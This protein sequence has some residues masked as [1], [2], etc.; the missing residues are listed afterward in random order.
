M[1][2]R[3]MILCCTSAALLCLGEALPR[4]GRFTRADPGNHSEPVVEEREIG[5]IWQGCPAGR[6]GF[7]CQVGT[8]T[9]HNWVEALLY[10]EG[11]TWGGQTDWRL[12]NVRELSSIVDDQR[13]SPAIDPQVFPQTPSE[14]FWTSTPVF[15]AG[16]SAWRVNFDYGNVSSY[17]VTYE[18]AVR[19]VRGGP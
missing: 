2:K 14:W 11:L 8:R 15:G 7:D 18:Y 6:S 5:L 17:D 16:S 13:S 12:P 3:W 4:T 10:C 9:R 1:K 19:C